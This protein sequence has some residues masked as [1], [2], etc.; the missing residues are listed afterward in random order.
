MH[1]MP[2]GSSEFEQMERKRRMQALAQ[3]NTN[4][5][6]RDWKR[7]M[8]LRDHGQAAKTGGGAKERARRAKKLGLKVDL[9]EVPAPETESAGT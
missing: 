6:I 3:A 1:E 5:D 8:K 2:E 4:R 9:A 7:E